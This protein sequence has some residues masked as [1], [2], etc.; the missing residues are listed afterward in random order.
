MVDTNV[1]E[2]MLAEVLERLNEISE[3]LDEV[4]DSIAGLIEQNEEV[5]E[6]LL[7]LGYPDDLRMA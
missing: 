6:K 3:R 5:V 7:N 4:E 1:V 2:R